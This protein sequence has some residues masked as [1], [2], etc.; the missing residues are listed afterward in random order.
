MTE[1]IDTRAYTSLRRE[2]AGLLESEKSDSK[3]AMEQ[4]RVR[5]YWEVG[6]RLHGAIPKSRSGKRAAY[7]KEIVPQ[8][9][10]DVDVRERL[11]YEMLH[12]Y[13][14]FPKLPTSAVLGWSH[15]RG[16][17][18]VGSRKARSYYVREADRHTWS[19]RRLEMHIDEKAFE[20]AHDGGAGPVL[21]VMRRGRLFTY[22]VVDRLG[23]PRLDLGFRIGCADDLVCLDGAAP[24]DIVESARTGS[25]ARTKRPYRIR[26]SDASEE[27]IY[28]YSA[29]MTRVVDGDTLVLD[30]DCGF[31]IW[32]D[33]T[34]RLRGID[35]P[36]MSTSKGLE[37]QAILEE[38]LSQWPHVVISTRTRDKYGRYL[39]DLFHLPGETEAARVLERGTCLNEELVAKGLAA[40]YRRR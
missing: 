10:R 38:T 40:R 37:V 7:G 35:A 24:G 29:L 17:L 31:G 1:T 15:Y 27:E 18:R 25:R 32:H 21:P 12:F 6:R 16:L 30:V 8:L 28:T 4:Q 36:E 3:R 26:K 23:G 20:L 9:A 22:P 13:R 33:P 14:A 34:I 2:V 39:A 11:L 5:S 19:V